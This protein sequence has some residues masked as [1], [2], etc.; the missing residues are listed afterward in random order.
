MAKHR[1][2]LAEM[3]DEGILEAARLASDLLGW[4]SDDECKEFAQINDIELFPEEETFSAGWNMPGYMPDVEPE[5]FDSFDDAKRHIIGEI[6]RAEEQA[7][8]E[9]SA[10]NL[11]A[12]AEDINLQSGDFSATCEGW[13]YWVTKG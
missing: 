9:G 12:F 6:K 11:C 7:E 10:E 3:L 8:T 2:K 4:L 5:E 13:V 1:D